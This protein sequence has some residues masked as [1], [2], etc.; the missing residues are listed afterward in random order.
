MTDI[1]RGHR[2]GYPLSQRIWNRHGGSEL[3][4]YHR[5]SAGQEV[6]NL[7]GQGSRRALHLFGK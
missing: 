2:D 3:E 5:G 1:P 4:R 6:G 7:L